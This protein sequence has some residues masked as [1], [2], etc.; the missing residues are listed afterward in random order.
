MKDIQILAEVSE[1][2]EVRYSGVDGVFGLG[3]SVLVYRPLRHGRQ[4][5]HVLD[6][7]AQYHI[8]FLQPIVKGP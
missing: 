5:D 7:G 1:A 4:V 2:V 8:C 6:M 3:P